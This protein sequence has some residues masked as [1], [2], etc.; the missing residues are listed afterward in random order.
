MIPGATVTLISESRGTR[1]ASVVTNTTRRLRHSQR[2]RRHLHDSGRRC[3]RSRRLKRTGVAVSPG[4]RVA[5]GTLDDRSRRPRSEAGRRHGRD[6]DDPGGERREVLHDHDRIGRRACRSPTAATT[7]C[8]A[9]CPASPANPGGL[10]PASRL[11]G[12][13]D[14]NF[15]LDGATS[16][17]PG[18]QSSGDARE[19]R[20]DSGSARRDVDLSGRVRPRQRSAGQRRHQERHEPVPGLGLRRRAQLEVEREQQDEHPQRRSEAVPGRARLGLRDRRPDRQARRRTTSCSSSSR[21]SSS[22]AP[23]AAT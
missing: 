6:A 9:S 15:M 7:R 22:R 21:R 8:S 14:S 12:G 17:D 11:G 3:R 1:L 16:M 10:T 4:S 23:S 13:G 19:R 5:L 20:G 18:R 2:H